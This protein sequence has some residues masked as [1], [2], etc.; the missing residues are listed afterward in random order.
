MGNIGIWSRIMG[1]RYYSEYRVHEL[2]FYP[3]YGLGILK[4]QKELLLQIKSILSISEP[5]PHKSLQSSPIENL[6]IF[7]CPQVRLVEEYVTSH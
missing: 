3:A 2:M 7:R 6:S 4:A 1:W 5:L